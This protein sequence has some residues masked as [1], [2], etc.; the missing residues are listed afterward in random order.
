MQNL[1]ELDPELFKPLG[2]TFIGTSGE[3]CKVYDIVL[4]A[5]VKHFLNVYKSGIIVMDR[6][7][8]QVYRGSCYSLAELG[9]LM[10]KV[11]IEDYDT[12]WNRM[13]KKLGMCA[14]PRRVCKDR[15]V[16]N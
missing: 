16:G 15:E 14:F 13:D 10:D 8:D 7:G 3:Q 4:S 9:F 12:F 5:P 11:S 2:W 6:K 1:F